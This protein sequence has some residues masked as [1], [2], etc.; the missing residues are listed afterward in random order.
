[1][2]RGKTEVDAERQ[3]KADQ[4]TSASSSS[5]RT[6]GSEKPVEQGGKKDCV[7]EGGSKLSSKKSFEER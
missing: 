3:K 6:K 5:P 2:K 7:E 1:M 4:P